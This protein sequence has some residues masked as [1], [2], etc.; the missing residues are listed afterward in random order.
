MVAPVAYLS[1]VYVVVAVISPNHKKY[2]T[3]NLILA[4]IYYILIPMSSP[5]TGQKGV[6]KSKQQ[7]AVLVVIGIYTVTYMAGTFNML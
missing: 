5:M 1:V 7:T 4:T 6:D 3:Y 2:I